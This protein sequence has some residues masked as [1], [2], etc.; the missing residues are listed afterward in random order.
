MIFSRSDF[1]NLT[2][3]FLTLKDLSSSVVFD[4]NMSISDI[5]YNIENLVFKTNIYKS[6]KTFV[7]SKTYYTDENNKL[8]SFK[9]TIAPSKNSR[10]F[11]NDLKKSFIIKWGKNFFEEFM[12]NIMIWWD[13]YNYYL[14]LNNNILKFNSIISNLIKENGI[15]FFVQFT[16]SDKLIVDVSD[17][18]IL[19]GLSNGVVMNFKNL[20]L[21]SSLDIKVNNY[22]S[23]FIDT[24][25]QCISPYD[26]VKIKNSIT[27]DLGVYT[28]F[29]IITLIKKAVSNKL[30]NLR[31][32]TGY[33]VRDNYF[34]V[35]DKVAVSNKELEGLD[36]SNCLI[37]DN[38]NI[39]NP[40]KKE[41]K[42]KILV[43]FR[44]KP[45][46][47]KNNKIPVNIELKDIFNKG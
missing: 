34:T 25:K 27:I 46:N 6:S 26:I 7:L 12:N 14:M 1:I 8:D 40:E 41:N 17:N 38:V 37:L 35:I 5:Y 2:S 13:N 32:G 10:L 44:I 4:N 42:T 39:K 45:F 36:I 23:L 18:H 15:S 29:N 24:L 3:S 21:F 11:I 22:K 43:S 28:R 16:V 30:E 9:F 47:I 33:L 20:S 19:L 31:V